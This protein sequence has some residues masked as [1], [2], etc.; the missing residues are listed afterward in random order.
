MV[1]QGE[2]ALLLGRRGHFQKNFERAR[3]GH[4]GGVSDAKKMPFY[5]VTGGWFTL[6]SKTYLL[7]AMLTRRALKSPLL[8]L[9]AMKTVESVAL[10]VT[11]SITMADEWL[12]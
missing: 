1:V 3:R 8:S 10:K 9:A 12:V 4:N 2:M 5:L 7:W 11:R 6:H